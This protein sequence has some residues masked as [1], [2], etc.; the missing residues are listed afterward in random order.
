MAAF[1]KIHK[2]E[3]DALTCLADEIRTIEVLASLADDPEH[4]AYAQYLA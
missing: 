1:E 3:I 4:R 2:G